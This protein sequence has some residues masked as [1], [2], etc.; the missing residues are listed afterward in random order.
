MRNFSNPDVNSAAYVGF[1]VVFNNQKTRYADASNST[2]NDSNQ[3]SQ[4]EAC[5]DVFKP[6]TVIKADQE[7]GQGPI[8]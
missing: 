3:T 1:S 6:L 2:G 7:P 5:G 8:Q 4:L